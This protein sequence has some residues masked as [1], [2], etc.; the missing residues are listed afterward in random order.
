MIFVEILMF[1][2]EVR[3]VCLD[4]DPKV[5]RGVYRCF[6]H[7]EECFIVPFIIH[8]PQHP[9]LA[10]PVLDVQF[11]WYLLTVFG[12]D[13]SIALVPHSVVYGAIF[14]ADLDP[15]VVREA[16]RLLGG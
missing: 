5:R 16:S 1:V 7:L 6:Q 13:L 3:D 12:F 14:H 8:F 4:F 10:E 9:Q 11:F 15:I 2:Y